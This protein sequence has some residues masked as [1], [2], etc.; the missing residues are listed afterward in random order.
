MLTMRPG[1]RTAPLVLLL[2]LGSACS[3]PWG[4]DDEV[5]AAAQDAAAA[6]SAGE[7]D[8]V[9]FAGD[10]PAA[11]AAYDALVAGLPGAPEVTVDEVEVGGD[12]GDGGATA[13]LT[14]AWD[15]G[16]ATWRYTSEA[17]LEEGADDWRLRWRPDLVAPG[18]TEDE[19]LVATRVA[20]ERGDVLGAGGTPLVEPRPVVRV[21]VDRAAVPPRVAVAA[22]RAVADAVDVETVPY[23]ERVRSAGER[24]FVEAIVLRAADLDPAARASLQDVRGARLVT[25]TLPLAPTRDFAAALLGGVGPATAEVV[26]DSDGRVV[27]GDEVGLSGL[28]RRYD[29]QLTGTPGVTVEA[30]ASD[31]EGQPRELFAVAPV[32]GEPLRTSLDLDLQ[33]RAQRVLA[34]VGPASGLVALRPST[35]EVLAAASGPGSDGYATAT[36]GQYAP[37]STFKV[38][39]SLALLREGLGPDSLVSCP[40]TVTVDGREFENYDDYPASG[41]GDITLR[42]AVARSCNTAF[43]GAADR[44]GPDALAS[45]AAA[46]GL[47]V[48][49][50]LGYPAFLGEVPRAESRTGAAAATIGQGTVLASPL[51]LAAVTASAVAGEAVLP[52]LLPDVEVDQQQPSAPLTGAEAQ[53][54]R[55][56]MRAVVTDG[57]GSLLADLAPPEVVAK[58][59]TAEF[60]TEQPPRTHAW[61]VAAQGDLAVAVLVEEGASGSSTAGPLLRAF[62]AG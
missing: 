41:L 26:E 19:R 15:L 45:A 59:G 31:D 51:A 16:P 56:M 32:A 28:Q 40:A 3:A 27:A 21:G 33:E 17:E 38:V 8:Q 36:F 2:A 60:G 6:L 20:A 55:T 18:L 7:T 29:A 46:L 44:L 12:A 58:T 52:R 37:G 61:M 54:L 5:R 13:T 30:V 62:L 24:A 22:A 39:T 14:W 10:E 57:S 25:D 47:G 23:V 50:D 49:H 1:H 9:R 42:D 35:G 34:D 43:I 4:G 11:R 53:A 48:D